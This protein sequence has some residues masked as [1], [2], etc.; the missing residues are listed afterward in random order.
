MIPDAFYRTFEHTADLGIEVE[1]A[2]IEQLFA[3]SA[4]AMFD[5]MFGLESIGLTTKR[6]V[7]ASA[8]N[9][10][11]LMVAWLNELLYVYSVEG[12]IFSEFT[13]F[14]LTERSVSAWGHGEIFDQAEHN[15][16]LEIKAATYHDLSVRRENGGW[17]ARI[18]FDV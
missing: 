13:D 16:S 3:R 18:I 6:R 5:I 11:E 14:D 7:Q 15:A 2:E 4:L 17:K 12:M 1:A 10:N 9:L 8:D